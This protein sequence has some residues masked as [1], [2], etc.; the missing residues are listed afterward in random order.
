MQ[1]RKTVKHFHEP[2]QLHEFTFSCY[3]RRPLLTN[4]DWRRRLARHINSAGEAEK[5]D[6][7]AFVYMPEH[8]HILTY[9]REPEPDLGRYLALLKQ[10]FSAEIK[11]LL[12][13]YKSPLLEK[14]TVQER[15]GKTCFRYWQEG[16]GYDRNIWTREVILSSIDY[17]H[18]NPVRRRLCQRAIDWPWSSARY[19]CSNPQKQQHS[20]L[21]LIHGLPLGALD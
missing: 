10:P 19:Y 14:L 16:P 18:L 8:V 7:V 6:L 3:Q 20:E 9:P 21:P 1:H 12:I 15:P 11:D 13:E 17:I 2:G 4:D 5:I